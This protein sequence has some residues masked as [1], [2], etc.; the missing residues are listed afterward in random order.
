MGK[1]SEKEW[2]Y[3]YVKLSHFVVHLKLA[4]YCKSTICQNKIKTKFKK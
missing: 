4:Q 1:E 3:V 2:I